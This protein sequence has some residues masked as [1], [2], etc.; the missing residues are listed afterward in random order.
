MEQRYRLSS[1]ATQ[2]RNDY[3]RLWKDAKEQL[4]EGRIDPDPMPDDSSRRWGISAIIRPSKGIAAII[5]NVAAEIRQY[6][7]PSQVI[8]DEPNLHTT[9]RSIEFHRTNV[10]RDD[11]KVSGYTQILRK[12]ARNFRPLRVYYA[13]LTAN[14]RGVMAQGWPLG[15]DLQ[16]FRERFQASLRTSGLLTGPEAEAI[17]KTAH[18]SLVVFT[19]PLIATPGLVEFVEQHRTTDYGISDTSQVELVRYQRTETHVEL[20]TLASICFGAS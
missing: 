9:V 5:A 13:G 19:N 7:G 20:V 6:V 16:Q 2:I 8:Y 4:S 15:D 3:E 12:I 18:L 17:R 11:E 1:N 14:R 10:A